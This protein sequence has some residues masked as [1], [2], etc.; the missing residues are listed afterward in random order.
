LGRPVLASEDFTPVCTTEW[1]SR[2]SEAGVRP[3]REDHRPQR[4]SGRL[5]EKWADDI[6]ETQGHALNFPVI[7]DADKK[8]SDCTT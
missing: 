1:A 8:V 4:R 2:A 3:A 6:K 7:A 5:D